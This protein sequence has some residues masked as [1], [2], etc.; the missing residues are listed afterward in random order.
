MPLS[1]LETLL[2]TVV[3]A[4]FATKSDDNRDK[5]SA[6]PF[7]VP[8]LCFMLNEYFWTFVTETIILNKNYP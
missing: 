4:Q 1:F 7:A 6:F 8:A 2:V 5:A 3:A